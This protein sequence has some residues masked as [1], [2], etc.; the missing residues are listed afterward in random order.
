MRTWQ[1][2]GEQTSVVTALETLRTL[3]IVSPVTFRPPIS[4]AS[5]RHVPRDSRTRAGSC[6]RLAGEPA[7]GG[8]AF[9]PALAVAVP[10]AEVPLRLPTSQPFEG[11]V[12]TAARLGSGDI[13]GVGVEWGHSRSREFTGGL[14]L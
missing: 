14:Q 7:A 11:C 4:P 1:N 3:M 8:A 12:G 10:E 9:P 5:E 2:T 6:R 13:C